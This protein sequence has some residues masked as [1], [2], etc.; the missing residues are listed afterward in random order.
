MWAAV[1]DRPLKKLYWMRAPVR[2]YSNFLVSQEQS[3]QVVDDPRI[4]RGTLTG[5]GA[6][7]HNVASRVGKTS[8]NRLGYGSFRLTD[9]GVWVKTALAPRPLRSLAHAAN[10]LSSAVA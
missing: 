1:C 9:S 7:G 6:A 3:N 4:K 5:R 2:L 8:I 10:S